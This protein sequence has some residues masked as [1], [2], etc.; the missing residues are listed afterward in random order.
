MLGSAVRIRPL[1]PDSKRPASAGFLLPGW[2]GCSAEPPS[3]SSDCAAITTRRAAAKPAGSQQPFGCC[4]QSAPC[5]Q[6]AKGPLRRAFCCLVGWGVRQNRLP[7]RA[8]AQ[9]SR[10]GAQR[11][12]P[13]GHNSLSAVVIN[14]P[15][16]TRQQRACPGGDQRPIPSPM[17]I[18][19][20]SR[21][22]IAPTIQ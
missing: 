13:Q 8:I 21:A 10:R 1:L 5:Y 7:V 17:P 20:E 22:S 6:T 15:L 19:N 16:A 12:S 9:Q 2:M 4:D 3:G 11:R 18:R 14:P